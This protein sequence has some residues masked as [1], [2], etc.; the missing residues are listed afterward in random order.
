ML[1]A[2]AETPFFS[3]SGALAPSQYGMPAGANAR[4]RQEL[5]GTHSFTT[6]LRSHG[7]DMA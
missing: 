2:A 7:R 1:G 4:T 3:I 5:A 6:E